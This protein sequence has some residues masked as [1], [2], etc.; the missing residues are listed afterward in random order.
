MPTPFVTT[1]LAA[2]AIAAV[3]GV[4]VAALILATLAILVEG[5]VFYASGKV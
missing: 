2:A 3:C 5:M 1:M 4:I